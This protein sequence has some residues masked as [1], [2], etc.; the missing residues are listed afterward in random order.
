MARRQGSLFERMV[1]LTWPKPADRIASAHERLHDLIESGAHGGRVAVADVAA[2]A[3]ASPHAVRSHL[4][5]ASN[6]D[7]ANSIP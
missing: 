7:Q 3:M 4:A 5:D 6:R 1:E 2:H